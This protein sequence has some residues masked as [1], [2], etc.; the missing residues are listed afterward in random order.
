MAKLMGISQEEMFKNMGDQID[1]DE[2]ASKENAEMWQ[3]MMGFGKLVGMGNDAAPGGKMSF[4][5][6]GK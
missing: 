2:K 1:I 3:R 4:G 5:F 6:G